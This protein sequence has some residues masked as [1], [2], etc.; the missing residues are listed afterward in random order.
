M[1][2][3]QFAR[4][5]GE[6]LGV[7]GIMG[8]SGCSS[9][10]TDEDREAN[11]T[12]TTKETREEVDDSRHNRMDSNAPDIPTFNAIHIAEDQLVPVERTEKAVYDKMNM[13]REQNDLSEMAYDKYLAEINRVHSRNMHVH[14]FIAHEDHLDRESSERAAYYGYPT[15]T[16]AEIIAVFPVSWLSDEYGSISRETIAAASVDGWH[17]SSGHRE[18]LQD[19]DHI[20][21]GVGVYVNKREDDHS[22]NVFITAGLI[23]S[24]PAKKAKAPNE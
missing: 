12:K 7:A 6:T 3:R 18:I 16:I 4:R 14:E 10:A 19:A 5:V 23:E 22:A 21:S 1:R 24:Q 11:A 13:Y 9:T 20:T 15:P 17:K 2:R 8:I